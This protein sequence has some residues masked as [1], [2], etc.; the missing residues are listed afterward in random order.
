MLQNNHDLF[1]CKCNQCL[2]RQQHVLAM[3]L[4]LKTQHVSALLIVQENPC[5]CD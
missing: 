4:L 2:L 5:P 1:A 3:V